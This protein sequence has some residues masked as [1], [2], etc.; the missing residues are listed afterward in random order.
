MIIY[1]EHWVK[2][3][4]L[5]QKIIKQFPNS[6]IISIKHY[7]N[8]FDKN[9][10]DFVL[11]KSIILASAPRN[12]IL[13]APKN[14]WYT[15]HSFFL[16]TSLNCIFDCKYCYLKW[17]FKNSFPVIFVDYENIAVQ[18]SQ[19][20]KELQT[21]FPKEE[22]C[23][24]ANNYSDGLA[25]ENITNFHSFFI[26]FF[27]SFE[28][29]ILESRTK[30][31]NIAHLLQIWKNQKFT[32]YE[33]AFSLN[34]QEIIEKYEIWTANLEQRIYSI[35]QLL[36]SWFQV[37]IR[38][39]PL[40]AIPN[41]INIYSQFLEYLETQ[42]DFSKIHSVFLWALLY[43]INDYKQISKKFPDLDILDGL[44]LWEDNFVR[45]PQLDRDKLYQIFQSKFNKNV[46]QFG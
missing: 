2:D 21:S 4:E 40:L 46:V 6:D 45:I 37:W 16:R 27:E 26:P 24:Y 12:C 28:W 38:F 31:H 35:N 29:V 25:L 32:N 11:E 9:I 43:T 44:E 41:F 3:L 33:I 18:I 30:S 8:I 23:F 7:K 22:I 42:L 1:I 20:I 36:Q 19:K 10:G 39:L 34:P 14:Y 17:A 13:P 5:T 15:K